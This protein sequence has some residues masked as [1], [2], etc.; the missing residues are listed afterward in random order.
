M[1]DAAREIVVEEVLPFSVGAVWTALTSSDLIERWLMP[2]DFS[3]E[4]GR[5]FHFRRAP[6]GTWDGIVD[7]EILECI[8]CERLVYSWKGGDLD[9]VVTWQLRPMDTG[10][11]LKMVHSG[12][13]LPKDE[14]A[15]DGMSQGWGKIVR[16]GIARVIAESAA[17][18]QGWAR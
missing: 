15:F 14:M 2:N 11:H 9:T 5:L 8:P 3:L 13:Q 10:T 7:C 16:I 12:F 17:S 4:V 1:T 6:I 18:G